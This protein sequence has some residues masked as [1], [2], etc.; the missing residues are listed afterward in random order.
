VH[1]HTLRVLSFNIALGGEVVDIGRVIEAIHRSGADVVGLQECDGRAQRIASL[2][3]WPHVDEQ[4][5][6]VSRLPLSA[7]PSGRGRYLYLH[8]VPGGVVALGNIHLPS[9]PYGPTMLAR[10]SSAAEVL[11]EEHGPRM[12]TLARFLDAWQEVLS[13]GIPLVITGDFNAPSHR[14]R[15]ELAGGDWPVTRTLEALGMVDAYRH[16]H[17][18]RDGITW[19]HGYPHPHRLGDEPLDRIDFVFASIDSRTTSAMLIGPSDAPDVD[20]GIDPWPSDHLAVLAEILLIPA[21]PPPYVSVESPVVRRGEPF[22]V[23]FHAPHPDDRIALEDAAGTIVAHQPPMEVDRFGLVTFGSSTLKGP[24]HAIVLVDPEG[25]ELS[26][27]TFTVLEP[28]ES[29]QLVA[30]P[31]PGGATIRWSAAPARKFD[32]IG[33]YPAGDAD[34]YGGCI[35]RAHTGATVG[36]EWS[37]ELAPGDYTVRLLSDDSYVV[38]AETQLSLSPEIASHTSG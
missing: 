2:L 28:G 18:D 21:E 33:V 23:R 8:V 9:D 34:L 3:G 20:V 32:W 16:V 25:N 13:E 15:Q 27:A 12:T 17:P 36:G 5:Q 31:S 22:T 19:T 38:L 7:P 24:D 4:H 29:P 26:R 35:A 10:G 37:V 14:D 30:G 6:V 1:T 11:D